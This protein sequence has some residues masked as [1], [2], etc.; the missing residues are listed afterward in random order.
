MCDYDAGE[1][2]RITKN[3]DVLASSLSFLSEGEQTLPYI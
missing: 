2:R 1:E 3:E